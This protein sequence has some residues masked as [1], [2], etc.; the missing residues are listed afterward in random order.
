M[1][2]DTDNQADREKQ[3]KNNK[4]RTHVLT[5]QKYPSNTPKS[6]KV[7]DHDASRKPIGGSYRSSIESDI[8]FHTVSEIGD[9]QIL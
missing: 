6:S 8:A 4:W 9:V 5:C 1:Y 3:Y 7:K 2:S